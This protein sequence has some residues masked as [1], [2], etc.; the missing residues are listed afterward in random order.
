MSLLEMTILLRF[1]NSYEFLMTLNNIL[2]LS[3]DE[4]TWN[5]L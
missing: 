4:E 3:G 5:S 1:K 2:C